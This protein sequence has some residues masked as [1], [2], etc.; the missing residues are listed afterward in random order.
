MSRK[1][2]CRFSDKGMRKSI[3]AAPAANDFE[4][5]FTRGG[6]RLCAP[7]QANSSEV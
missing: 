1:N 6:R 5:F 3:D 7:P 2:G 4:S